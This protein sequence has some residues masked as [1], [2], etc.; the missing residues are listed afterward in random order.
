VQ[1]NEEVAIVVALFAVLTVALIAAVLFTVMRLLKLQGALNEHQVTLAEQRTRA[2][3]LQES[4][5]RARGEADRERDARLGAEKVVQ[6]LQEL[7]SGVEK[8]REQSEETHRHSEEARKAIE[9]E[10]G[11]ATKA[12]EGLVARYTRP[13]GRGQLSEQ[14]LATIFEG[15]GL[16]EGVNYDREHRVAIEKPNG[17]TSI[18]VI[19]YYLRLPGG[20]GL[21]LDA[22]YPFARGEELV[23]SN[24]VL[25]KKARD[26]LRSSLRAHIKGL[27]ERR[28]Q[29]ARDCQVD[30]VFLVLP[31]WEDYAV[32]RG[33]APD[34]WEYARQQRVSIVPADG[35]FEIAEAVALVHRLADTTGKIARLHDPVIVN[36]MFDTSL[37]L[38]DAVIR[39]VESHNTHGNHIAE[40]V[41]A[42]ASNGK[43]RHDVLDVLGDAANRAEP[44]PRAAEIKELPL[45]RAR[46]RR[47]Q[48]AEKAGELAG[49]SSA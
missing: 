42:F 23:S 27:A 36:Q 48:L 38:L 13:K 49:E 17:E 1:D 43:F 21:A 14:W 3:G 47:D 5:S 8:A 45:D 40:L 2:E 25:R 28:Y 6:E 41:R 39:A 18:G 15:F 26:D 16:R 19:D 34:L 9:E 20:S 35:V 29:D 10:S 24:D 44:R 22:K 33:V 7:R 4:L 30:A 12:I 31:S 46:K 11:K 32:A 37:T